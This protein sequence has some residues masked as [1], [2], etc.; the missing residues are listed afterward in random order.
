[1]FPRESGGR[2]DLV[3][4]VRKGKMP[5]VHPSTS[6][7]CFRRD[8]LAQ[9]L[10]MPVAQDVVLSDAYIKFASAGLAPGWFF[11]EPLGTLRLHGTNRYSGVRDVFPLKTRIALAT[12]RAMRDRWPEMGIFCDGWMGD[13]M[14]DALWERRFSPE[15]WTALKDYLSTGSKPVRI[16]DKTLRGLVRRLRKGGS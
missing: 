5:I 9:I 12:T 7:L 1:V 4:S 3:A 11:D 16:L 10:P 13:T 2:K 8:F 14:A 6:G 15:A